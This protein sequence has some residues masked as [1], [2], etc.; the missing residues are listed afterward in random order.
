MLQRRQRKLLKLR[1]NNRRPR[2]QLR[3]RLETLQPQ[4]CL[5]RPMLLL[6]VL[7]WEISRLIFKH[8]SRLRLR[9]ELPK[10]KLWP[11][12]EVTTL[13]LDNLQLNQLKGN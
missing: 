9:Q 12:W 2:R 5:H 3:K 8:R 11:L 7:I 4:E 10:K 13:M 1:K 6:L